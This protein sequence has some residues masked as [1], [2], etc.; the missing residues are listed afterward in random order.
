MQ[1]PTHAV[2]TNGKIIGVSSI[3]QRLNM[4]LEALETGVTFLVIDRKTSSG[5]FWISNESP[6]NA[7]RR[8]FEDGRTKAWSDAG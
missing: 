8:G 2:P 1:K 7:Y 3:Y 4:V 5:L 6:A